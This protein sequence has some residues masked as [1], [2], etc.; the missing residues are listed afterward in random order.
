VNLLTFNTFKPVRI[1]SIETDT[2]IRPGR[3]SADIEA[4]ELESDTYAPG[5]TL[6]ATV[7]VRPFKG[8]PQRFPVA[9]KLPEDLPEGRYVV[10]ICDDINNARMDLR[11]NPTLNRPQSL[12][13]LFEAI[14]LQTN[15]KRNQL[16][17]R[18]PLPAAGVALQGKTL[19]NLPGSMVQILGSSKRSGAQAISG[20][21]VARHSTEWII[22]GSEIVR[23]AVTKNKKAVTPE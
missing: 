17:A 1:K 20:A 22:Q 23:F 15:V 3:R 9:L 19:P 18:L 5:D 8:S 14:R 7:F 4:V 11:D 21:L 16:V 10:T 2:I 6:K 13:Q 12:E